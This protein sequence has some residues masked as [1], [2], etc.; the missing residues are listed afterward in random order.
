ML[1][2]FG[3]RSPVEKWRVYPINGALIRERSFLEVRRDGREGLAQFEAKEVEVAFRG[4]MVEFGNDRTEEGKQ[5][6]CGEVR[7][8]CWPNEVSDGSQ[9]AA[10]FRPRAAAPRHHEIG[11]RA[12]DLKHWRAAG[13]G[14][15]EVK[16]D[17]CGNAGGRIGK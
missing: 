16:C 8:I 17:D 5:L 6:N 10:R 7:S 15:F 2:G 11:G 13:I 4:R 1:T 12:I 9:L 3:K 14:E